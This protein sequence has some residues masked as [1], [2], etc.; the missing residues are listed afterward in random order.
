MIATDY[1]EFKVTAY[2]PSGGRFPT[3][4]YTSWFMADSINLFR[5]HVYGLSKVTGKWV[6]LKTVYN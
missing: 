3:L 5:G 4:H 2:K 6:L 1:S